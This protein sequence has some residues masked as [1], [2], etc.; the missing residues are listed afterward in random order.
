MDEQTANRI[1]EPFFSTKFLGR[2]LGLAAVYGIVKNHGG[3]FDVNTAPG[4]GSVFTIYL[5]AKEERTEPA[6]AQKAD[7]ESGARTI[8]VIE[9]EDAVARILHQTLEKLGYHTLQAGNGMQA[10]AG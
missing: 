2:G 7:M 9:D 10:V 5:S 8:L 6:A 1:F 4:Q 3:Y